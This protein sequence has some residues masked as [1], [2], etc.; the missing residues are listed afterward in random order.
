M[1]SMRKKKP[2]GG[3]QR[4][5]TKDV[6]TLQI[7]NTSGASTSQGTA[8]MKERLQQD[9][10]AVNAILRRYS[11][12]PIVQLNRPPRTVALD[13]LLLLKGGALNLSWVI[14]TM[15]YAVDN[16]NENPWGYLE[17]ETQP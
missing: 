2:A 11:Y 17:E 9:I 7:D 13:R 4:A 3:N 14:E 6:A 1:N 5:E 16:P 10:A 12:T 15:K 8:R